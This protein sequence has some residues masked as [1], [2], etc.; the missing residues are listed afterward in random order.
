MGGEGYPAIPALPNVHVIG[1][2][3]PFRED[4]E[5]CVGMY[6]QGPFRNAPLPERG[7]VRAE[8]PLAYLW[9]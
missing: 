6:E 4:T 9:P 1:G 7:F 3:Y 5:N 8:I 2:H